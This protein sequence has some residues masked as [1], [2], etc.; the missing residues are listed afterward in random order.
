MADIVRPLWDRVVSVKGTL[1]GTSIDL[2]DIAPAD[3]R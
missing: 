2:E 3:I 1:K